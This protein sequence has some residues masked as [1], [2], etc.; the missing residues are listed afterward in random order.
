MGKITDL[1]MI[2][3]EKLVPYQKN[4]KKHSSAQVQAIANSIEEFGFLSP[5]L[6][7]KDYNII[8]GH[9]RVLA[10]KKLG[11]LEVPCI[12][13]EGLTE[14][15]RRA[16]ILADNKLTEMGDWDEDLLTEE[17]KTLQG[18]GFNIELTGFELNLDEE[19]VQDQEPEFNPTEKLPESNLYIY[20][21]SAFGTNSEKIVMIKIPEEEAER[22]LQAIE[23]KP[24]SEIVEKLME[25][26]R[27]V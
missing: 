11:V 8:A 14:E 9:G 24:V 19:E 20:S 25:G 15:Q 5:I 18:A 27:N 16:Y 7:D 22:F 4:A 3:L 23:N 10:C 12:F 2:Q 13:A 6:I 21:I 1:K 17:L 26:V